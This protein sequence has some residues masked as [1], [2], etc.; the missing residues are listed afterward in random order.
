[1]VAPSL[2]KTC[3]PFLKAAS[4]AAVQKSDPCMTIFPTGISDKDGGLSLLNI[5]CVLQ[6]LSG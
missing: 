5:L 2:V 1:M 3:P 4:E 6:V